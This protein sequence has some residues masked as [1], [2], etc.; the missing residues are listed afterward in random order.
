MEIVSTL[1]DYLS[2]SILHPI[3][4]KF[5]NEYILENGVFYKK[6]PPK[7]PDCNCVMVHNGYNY[8][9]KKNY[10]KIKIGRY[11]CPKCETS[12]QETAEFFS[13]IL[14][15]LKGPIRTVVL[16]MRSSK[17]SYR[18]IADVMDSI[19]PMGKDQIY[20]II[21]QI[22]EQTVVEEPEPQDIQMIFYDEQFPFVNGIPHVRMAIIDSYSRKPY[23]DD[24]V[25]S[26][27]SETI[28]KTFLESGLDFEKPTIVITDLD[29]RYPAILD[30][31]F[32]DNLIHQPCLFHLFKLIRSEFPINC[33]LSEELLIQKIFDVFYNHSVE[34]EWL[35]KQVEEEQKIKSEKTSK[36]YSG[37][38]KQKRRE[39]MR[40][41]HKFQI[42]RRRNKETREVRAFPDIIENLVRLLESK[43]NYGPIVQKRLEM[44]DR[45]FVKLTSFCEWH[46]IPTTSNA[47]ENY[48]SSTLKMGWKKLMRTVKGLKNHLKLMQMKQQE[49]LSQTNITI[50][51][52]FFPIRLIIPT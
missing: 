52:A 33:S 46:K 10:V 21:E 43:D 36:H 20:N 42:E 31:L 41:C 19:I 34:I 25:Q 40:L 44:I 47:I 26:N 14:D 11:L 51:D 29:R 16:K 24:V 17:A 48:F 23:I 3:L 45:D 12:L 50:I 30:D 6:Q 2:V 28:K 8:R 27:D 13:D 9:Q 37:W 15:F 22:I 7:C 32:K 39:F 1:F 5:S 35:E 4:S 38:L 18:D 49:I